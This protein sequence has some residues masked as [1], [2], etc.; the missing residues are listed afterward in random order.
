MAAWTKRRI[1]AIGIGVMLI[2]I[3]GSVIGF[4]VA[5]QQ[6][7]AQ[8]GPAQAGAIQA[9]SKAR[10]SGLLPTQGPL[11]ARSLPTSILIPAIGVDSK[12][13]YLG[14]NPDG[15]IQVPPLNDPPLTNEAAW[16][17]YSS[18]PGELGASVI[19]GHVDSAADGPSVFFR[20][21]ALKPGDLVDITLADRKVAVFKI[22]GVRLY[23][24]SQFP[25]ATV[26][27]FTDYAALRL[28]TCGGSFDEQTGHYL[29]NVI[30]FASLVSSH[31][32]QA[33]PE[34][35]T[36]VGGSVA[37]LLFRSAAVSAGQ[38]DSIFCLGALKAR[39]PDLVVGVIADSEREGHSFAEFICRNALCVEDNTIIGPPVQP[40]RR[41]R[42]LCRRQAEA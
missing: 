32:A 23:L 11:L 24:K 33:Q 19:E 20:L 27:G 6:H 30:A 38:P 3:G 40:C 1:M 28:I 37:D 10:G 15:T 21:G 41:R 12:L 22:T 35:L 34:R 26:Y 13:L 18:T 42:V 14:L 25:T 5:A 16:Y 17:K 39:A 9:P 31:P 8:P 29:S 4:A 7:A 2:A 36:K